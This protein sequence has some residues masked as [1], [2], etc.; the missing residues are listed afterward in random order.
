MEIIFFSFQKHFFVK[1]NF[2]K[3]TTIF[4]QLSNTFVVKQN[5]RCQKMFTQT[6][7]INKNKI[8]HLDETQ[9]HN[10]KEAPQFPHALHL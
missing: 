8:L 1:N 6:K 3:T 10:E 4:Q 5:F 7:S 2:N 9:L